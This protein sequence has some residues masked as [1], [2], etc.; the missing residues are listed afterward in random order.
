MLAD[1]EQFLRVAVDA[2]LPNN[3]DVSGGPWGQ[4][5]GVYVH[6]RSFVPEPLGEDPPE[7]AA[8]HL[9]TVQ[10]WPA[11]GSTVDFALAPGP[12]DEIIDVEAPLGYLATR[13]DQYFVEGRTVHFYRPPPAGTPGVRA[14]VQGDAAQG[15]RRRRRCQLNLELSAIDQDASDVDSWLE[16]CLQTCLVALLRVPL[17]T[18]GAHP[19]V[20]LR[21][22]VRR[23]A[24]VS[25]ER[26]RVESSNR[27]RATVVL[28]LRGE[29]ELIV[30]SGTP[31]PIGVIESIVHSAAVMGSTA[32][33]APDHGGDPPVPR[34]IEGKLVTVLNS[35]SNAAKI[36]LAGLSEPV[37]T[38]A[39]L[40][41]LDVDA[42]ANEL[43]DPTAT[44][45]HVHRAKL[46]LAVFAD[47][48]P[49]LPAPAEAESL[50]DLLD[51]SLVLLGAL[52]GLGTAYAADLRDELLTLGIL[53]TGSAMGA[54]AL[55]DFR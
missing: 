32:S 44:H 2:S 41:A 36:E 29:F 46:V 5:D 52:T 50:A 7:D 19:N 3:V 18:A 11:D 48:L 13:G 31:E 53:L 14:R 1:L 27:L 21:T 16:T 8:A 22:D 28:E 40:A 38:L 26:V 45:T 24:I 49:L 34:T 9:V 17:L 4:T 30:A 42:V 39:E 51:L 6:A 54:L 55:A 43:S 25:W 35:V 20:H 10:E 23:S 33:P 47:G 37:T 15:Y 12:E